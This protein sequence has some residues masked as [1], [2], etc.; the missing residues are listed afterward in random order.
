MIT[1]EPAPRPNYYLLLA[2]VGIGGVLAPI[3]STM[4]AVA[5]PELRQDF[6]I[7]HS[8][9]GWLISAYLI[10]MAVAQ[11]VGGRLSDQLGRA[12]VYRAG[13]IGFLT[14]SLAAVFAPS[15][16]TLVVFRTGQAIAGAVLI[17][18]GMAMLR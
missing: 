9:V 1:A 10:A 11:P 18:N 2:A 17:P 16:P 14:F 6:G 4:L 13:L 3:N 15:F 8:E 12:R 5:L 7:S